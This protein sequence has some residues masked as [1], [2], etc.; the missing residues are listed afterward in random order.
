MTKMKRVAEI[1][2]LAMN[3]SNLLSSIPAG[4]TIQEGSVTIVDRQGNDVS[5]SMVKRMTVGTDRIDAII[6]GG[7]KGWKYDVC[8][9]I[10]TQDYDFE[11]HVT[12][13]VN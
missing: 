4:Q 3:F 8:F 1:I 9:K 10:S 5:M 6:Q 11:E 2:P 7:T 12:L 13:T